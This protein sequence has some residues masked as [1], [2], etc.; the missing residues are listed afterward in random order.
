M[1]LCTH[2]EHQSFEGTRIEPEV[3]NVV[4]PSPVKLPYLSGNSKKF[5]TQIG[6]SIV[7]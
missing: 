3:E 4:L 2:V 5:V 7:L 6:L 1:F